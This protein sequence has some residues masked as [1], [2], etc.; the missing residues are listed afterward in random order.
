MFEYDLIGDLGKTNQSNASA[1]YFIG[2]LM[3]LGG[4][5]KLIWEIRAQSGMFNFILPI[6]TI[7][8]GIGFLILANREKKLQKARVKYSIQISEDKIKTKHKDGTKVNEIL[9]DEI[10]KIDFDENKVAIYDKRNGKIVV[11]LK[12]ISPEKKK[13][14]FIKNLK[15]IW[16]KSP[17][18]ASGI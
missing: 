7:S 16:K 6:I 13:N 15:N 3:L 17:G 12:L 5:G 4:I 14:E 8:G 2:A 10:R 18:Q 11:D 1:F 9:T